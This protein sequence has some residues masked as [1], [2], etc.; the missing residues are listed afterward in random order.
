MDTKVMAAERRKALADVRGTV[1]EV[2]FGTGLNLPFYPDAVERVVAIDPSTASAKR[3][4]KRIAAA[5]FP[6]EYVPVTGEGI[7]APDESF[8]AVVSTCTLC[9]VAD[10]VAALEQVRRVLKPGGCYHF[11]EHGLA[12]EPNVQKW[13]ARLNGLNG[14]L[15]GGCNI[16]RDIERLI[17][18]A[19]FTFDRI[20]KYYMEGDPKFAGWVTRG[21]ARPQSSASRNAASVS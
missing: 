17:R 5:P 20:D 8:D 10:P 4:R 6:V 2:G 11:L 15:L 9:T 18:L 21:V 13:Q 16:N 19:G 1:L 14:R 3:A 7:S 12:E